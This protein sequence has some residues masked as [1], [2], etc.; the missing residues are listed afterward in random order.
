MLV[1]RASWAL[2]RASGHVLLEGTPRDVDLDEVRQHLRELPEVIS[3]HDLHAWTLTSA[4]PALTAHVVVTDDCLCD[5]TASM[6][7]D[8]LQHCVANH[9][10]VEHST[11]QLEATT[12]ADHE[13]GTHG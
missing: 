8:R 2:L 1:L 4:L 5:G 13:P 7:L 12:H 10:D 9:F 3:V 6:V 11:F